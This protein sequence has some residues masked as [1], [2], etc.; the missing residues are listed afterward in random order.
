MKRKIL[1]RMSVVFCLCMVFSYSVVSAAG[2]YSFTYNFKHQLAM[3]EKKTATKE[4]ADFYIYT[5]SNGGEDTYF[6]IEQYK[7]KALGT[8]TYVDSKTINCQAEKK[9]K[10]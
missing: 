6:T 3:K 8:N 5:T 4:S 10:M 2:S 7:Y 9:W 1:K